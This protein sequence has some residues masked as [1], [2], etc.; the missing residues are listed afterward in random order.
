MSECFGF[1]ELLRRCVRFGVAP[2]GSVCSVCLERVATVKPTPKMAWGICN[3]LQDRISFWNIITSM[4]LSEDR[5][6]K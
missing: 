4:H 2:G 5:T 1:R 6:T 3:S